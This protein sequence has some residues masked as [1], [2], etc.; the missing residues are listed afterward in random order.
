MRIIVTWGAGFIGSHFL[1]RYVREY[2]EHVFINVDALTY[3]ADRNRINCERSPN[4]VFE[5][6]DIRDMEM[7]EKV[8]KKHS[9]THIIHFAAE[10]HVDNSIRSPHIFLETN[11]IGTSNLLMLSKKYSLERFHF[12]STDEVYGD[13]FWKS[14]ATEEAAL[15]PS[16]PYAVSKAS[17][18]MLVQSFLRTYDLDITISRG[19]NTYGSGQHG[20]K[21]MPTVLRS[22]H[23]KAPIPLY[24]D[25]SAQRDWLHVDDHAEGIWQIF[26]HAKRGAIYNIAGNELMPNLDLVKKMIAF[27]DADESL[28]S[29]VTDRPGHDMLYSISTIKIEN[30]L[31]FF[32]RKHLEDYFLEIKKS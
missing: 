23:N 29:F 22:I 15:E 6:C 1:N 16:S 4:Y 12:V 18:D 30:E 7:L 11:I 21:F 8:F 20:E 3:A 14:L 31:A 10:S 27:F 25:G 9:P 5:M 32:P 28:I 19:S 17:A 26:T 13:R 24:G 2:P